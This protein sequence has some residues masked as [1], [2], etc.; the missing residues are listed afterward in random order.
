METLGEMRKWRGELVIILIIISSLL[1][2]SSYYLLKGDKMIIGEQFCHNL[3]W[4]DPSLNKLKDVEM[5][6]SIR[7]AEF[8]SCMEGFKKGIEQ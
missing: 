5:T 8:W 6:E 7:R 3:I 4:N 1:I 2:I